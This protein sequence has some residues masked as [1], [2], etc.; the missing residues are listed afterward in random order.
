MTSTQV[1]QEQM[2]IV[3]AGHVDHGK[4]TVVGR[5]LADTDSLPEG[6][7]EQVRALCERN[8]K[9]FEYAFLLD[10]LKDE[11]SQGITIDAAR[12]F[13][14]T[15]VRDYIIIDAPGHIE[16]LKNM[17]TGAS[18]AEAAVLIID[19]AEGVQENSR[20]HGYMLSMLGISQV[21]VVVNKM[22]LVDYGRERFEEI[23]EEY[24]AFLADI[25]VEARGFV[26]VSGRE[27]D[28]VATHS[29]RTAWYEGPTVLE[30]LDAFSKDRPAEDQPFRMPVQDVYK[31]TASG[32]DR[33]LVVGTV[34]AGTL[35]VGDQ[36]AFY[37]SGKRSEVASIEGFN[38]PDRESVSVGE[39]AAFTLKEQV[40]ITRGELAVKVGE[41]EPEVTTRLKV[42]LFWMGRDSMVPGERYVLKT[43]TCKMPVEIESI[44]R[45]MDA[46]DLSSGAKKQSI[47]RHDVA[48]VVLKT[49]RAVA[50]DLA[51]EIS[52]T[53]RFVIVHNFEIQGGGIVREALSDQQ[54]WMRE[55]VQMRNA[56]WQTSMISRDQRSE[57]YNQRAT[58]VL[59][60]G[61]KNTGKKT[62]AK[63]LEERL[64]A[65]GKIVY[66]LG[67]SN[68]LYGIDADIKVP[69]E[70]GD[71]REHLRRLAEVANVLLDAGVIL[72][73]TALELTQ[74]ERELFETSV[75]E[76]RTLVVWLG[77]SGD[78]DIQRDLHIL[79][80]WE[81]VTAVD[82]AKSLLQDRNIIFRP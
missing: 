64:F 3:I 58:L 53:S 68:V 72:I 16:F 27:G 38:A 30:G 62:F 26:P 6:K 48:E 69:G 7:L 15:E 50:F 5:M 10:A 40:Y 42:S 21:L 67:I 37:P 17:V 28:N 2:N 34:E 54:Q 73:I 19:A 31:F 71:R 32:D 70:T 43:G 33:R 1:N 23:V 52:A 81:A 44:E 51:E 13:F 77:D 56:K 61:S 55:H 12:V 22:D 39:A 11:M 49:R 47:D 41:N 20:R 57:K 8:S 59:V 82:Q 74:E 45:V 75:G 60:T 24:R 25:G 66:F 78:T 46:S 35:R 18:R 9:P 76:G 14:R 4:S 29:E 79:P 65:D 80:P 63:A 36:V